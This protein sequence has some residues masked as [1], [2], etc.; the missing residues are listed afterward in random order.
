MLLLLAVGCYAVAVPVAG[1][2]A[3]GTVRGVFSSLHPERGGT[4]PGI[5]KKRVVDFITT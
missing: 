1:K 5:N 4:P 3:V 2:S